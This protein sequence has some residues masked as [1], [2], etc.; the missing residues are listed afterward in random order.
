MPGN[1]GRYAS[2]SDPRTWG[3]H[4]DA[5]ATEGIDGVGLVLTDHPNLAACDPDHC[6]DA[7]TGEIEPLGAERCSSR[8]RAMPRS[9]RAPSACAWSA[10]P[11]A[12]AASIS[13]CRR[14]RTAQHVEVYCGGADRYIT[15]SGDVL[16]DRPLG[17]ITAVI[18][19]LMAERAGAQQARDRQAPRR[20]LDG[21]SEEIVELIRDGA[22]PGADRSA[23]LFRAVAAMRAAGWSRERIIAT[24]RAHPPGSREM[25]RDRPR[26]HCPACRSDPAQG[27][28]RARRTRAKPRQAKPQ[29]GAPAQATAQRQ[30][31]SRAGRGRGCARAAVRR[32]ARRS[33]CL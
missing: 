3:S 1:G 5:L 19:A 20:D 22:P 12:S 29:P 26:R 2:V 21:L 32:A 31:A 18:R 24:L 6:R 14:D 9:P 28:R 25:F 13:T 27:R 8:R 4:E 11:R 16:Q 23:M 30:P 15:V 7:A 10:W 33:F 17:D